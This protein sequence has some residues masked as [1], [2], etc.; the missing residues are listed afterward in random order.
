MISASRDDHMIARNASFFKRIA[1]PQISRQDQ[2]TRS[3]AEKNMQVS[4]DDDYSEDDVPQQH[5]ANVPV[6]E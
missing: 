5:H 6:V 1:N 3:A 2:Q 4:D